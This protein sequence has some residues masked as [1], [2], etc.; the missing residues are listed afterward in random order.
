MSDVN[1]LKRIVDPLIELLAHKNLKVSFSGDEAMTQYDPKTGKPK[2]IILP[3]VGSDADQSVIDTFHGYIDHEI[4]HVL[5]Y[6]S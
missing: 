3:I 6:R 4:G 5:F 1:I 2:Q